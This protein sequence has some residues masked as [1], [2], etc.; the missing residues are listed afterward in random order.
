[1]ESNKEVQIQPNELYVLRLTGLEVI[2]IHEALVEKPY[3][4][5]APLIG[6]ISS[7]VEKIEQKVE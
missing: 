5:S 4:V 6:K 3:K 1:M 2:Q 7:Q